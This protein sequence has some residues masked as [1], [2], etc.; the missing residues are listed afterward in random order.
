MPVELN[1]QK[2]MVAQGLLVSDMYSWQFVAPSRFNSTIVI[3]QPQLSR[4][5][6]AVLKANP[7]AR[8]LR[9]LGEGGGQGGPAGCSW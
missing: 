6:T 8:G 2:L 9:L 1:F 5:Q 7:S 4:R 3:C